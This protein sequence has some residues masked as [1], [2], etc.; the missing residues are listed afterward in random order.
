MY[1]RVPL[2]AHNPLAGLLIENHTSYFSI[3]VF[4]SL[5]RKDYEKKSIYSYYRFLYGT[6]FMPRTIFIV[7]ALKGK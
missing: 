4:L 2:K 1:L 3:Q 7:K 5:I 6:Y